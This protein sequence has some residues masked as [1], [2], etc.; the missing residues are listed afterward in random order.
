MQKMMG[1]SGDGLGRGGGFVLGRLRA[2]TSLRKGWTVGHGMLMGG[3]ENCNLK[4]KIYVK[5]VK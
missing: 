1:A 2:N 5:R 3:D 4:K